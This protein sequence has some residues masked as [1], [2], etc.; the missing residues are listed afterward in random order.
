MFSLTGWVMRGA[1]WPRAA[2]LRG[3]WIPD[4]AE[5][6]QEGKP[7]FAADILSIAE[8]KVALCSDKMIIIH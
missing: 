3:A 6:L 5:E 7:R 4:G 8:R 1:M 2:A